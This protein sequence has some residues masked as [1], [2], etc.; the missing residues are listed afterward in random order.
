M[1]S[2]L[3][4]H[5]EVT[6]DRYRKL[7]YRALA[8][9]SLILLTGA[10]VRLTGSG[11]GCPTWPKCYGRVYPPLELHP[12]IEFGNRFISA[13]IA[14]G[15]L[16]TA[17]FAFKRKPFRRDLA[18]LALLL[19]L[20]VIAQAVL[21]GYTV[22][23]KLAPG[24]VMSHF[25]LSIVLLIPAVALAWRASYE[26]GERPRSTDR[27][28]VWS[29]R[30]LAPFCA[31]VLFMGTAAT[32]SGPHSGGAVGQHIKRLHFDGADTLKVVVHWHA[33]AALLFGLAV[34][35]VWLLKRSRGPMTVLEP[36]TILAILVATQGAVGTTQYALGLP[37][38]LV[39]IHVGLAV[40]C[41]LTVLWA[42]ARE[43][44]LQQRPVT[45]RAPSGA[46][47]DGHERSLQGV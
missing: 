44:R 26:P 11:L 10:A 16:A 31:L 4:S 6:P 13:L 7:T 35:A 41:W 46:S 40:L 18:I 28:V 8:V 33:T 29:V 25:L 19:P 47:P 5:L 20:G 14:I 3:A 45:A 12:M 37:G 34:V 15:V 32:A 27:A 21:G 36:I 43:G 23:N 38:E 9:L 42:V 17:F 24:F 39:E 22:E 2:R 1:P 30:A